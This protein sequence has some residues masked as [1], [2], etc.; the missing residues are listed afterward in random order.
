[1]ATINMVFNGVDNVSQIVSNINQQMQK[2]EK[3]A[4]TLSS[5][6][7]GVASALQIIG[8]AK[9]FVDR[10]AQSVSGLV[11]EYEH[12]LEMETRLTTVMGAR[13]GATSEMIQSVKDTLHAQESA[14]GYSYE[15]LT[16]GAQELATYISSAETLKGLMPIL[17]NMAKQANVNSE[18]GM[19]SYATMLGKV[20]GGDMGGMSKRGY[21]FT[22]AEK[23]AFKLMNEEERLAFITKTVTSSIGDQANALNALNPQ[24]VQSIGNALGDTRKA[25]GKT[26]KP[27]LNFFQMV[28]MKWKISFFET[29]N[30]GLQWVQKHINGVVI[31]LGALVAG[32]VAVGV[33]YL[34]LHAQQIVSIALAIRQAIVNNLAWLPI[35]G[36]ILLVI[37]ALGLFLAF[38]EQTFTAVGRIIGSLIAFVMNGFGNV[39]NFIVDFAEFFA[40]VFID[41][42]NS[43]GRLFFNVFDKILSVIQNVAGSIGA[44]FGQ[45]WS[46]GIE[47]FRTNLEK[48]KD[49]AYGKP[50]ISLDNRRYEEKSALEFANKGGDIGKSISDKF[51]GSIDKLTGNFKNVLTPAVESG[52]ANGMNDTAIGDM[53]IGSNGALLTKNV[54]E[55]DIAQ[56]YKD[57]LST[58]ATEKFFFKQSNMRPEINI[59]MNGTNVTAD[60]VRD[61]VASVISE[62]TNTMTEGLYGAT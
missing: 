45:D 6:L 46:S 18:E 13:F 12:E 11:G 36:I 14:T 52:V 21:V 3:K 15:M 58:R 1:M 56:D 4:E 62:M 24:S 5:K 27:F 32:L 30:N 48:L 53:S 29:I 2:A 25:L 28:T 26:L 7:M 49:N 9:S 19:M 20:M 44:I 23:Q 39:W 22:D 35:V 40:N 8:T 17:A 47:N 55:V 16:N 51:Q 33:A 42:I 59:E 31:A 60:D 54:D 10:L 57:L 41:P 38:S 34:A 37:G 43:V 61:K 50:K